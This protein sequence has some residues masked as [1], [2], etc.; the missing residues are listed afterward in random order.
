[1]KTK[2]SAFFITYSFPPSGG[3]GVQRVYKFVKYL[4]EFDV[5]TSV[6][7]ASNI[8]KTTAD[9]SLLSDLDSKT[10]IIR[11]LSIDPMFVADIVNRSTAKSFGTKQISSKKRNILNRL[12]PL[13]LTIRNYLRLPDQYIGW[14]P[15]AL[16]AGLKHVKTLSNPVIVASLPVY[17]TALVAYCLSK[18]TGAPLVIDFRD[19][20]IDDPYLELPTKFHRYIHNKLEKKIVCHA[21]H[22]VVY[23]EWLREIYIKKYPNIPTTVILNGFDAE[24]FKFDKLP[25]RNDNKIRIVYSGSIFQYHLEFLEMTFAALRQLDDSLI[26]RVEMIFAGGI[27]LISFDELVHKYELQEVVT[28]LGYLPHKEALKLLVTADAL[29]FTIPRNDVSSYTGKIFEYLASRRPI[30][31]FLC[32]HGLGGKLLAEFGHDAWIVDYDIE[33]ASNIFCN[34]AELKSVVVDYSPKLLNK[35]ERKQQAATLSNIIHKVAFPID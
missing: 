8:L 22:I 30:I 25:I 18:L 29:L 12:V 7:T 10:T 21:K 17:T 34:I 1:M 19:A 35:I 27:Q 31:S 20:W 6:L 15:F 3:S 14:F 16:I 28:K 24:D 13:L 4:P 2:S 32:E 11:T 23:G 26:N 33:R 9:S 5:Q